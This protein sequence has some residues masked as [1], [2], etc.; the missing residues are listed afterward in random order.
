MKEQARP[1]ELLL[2]RGKQKI[3]GKKTKM[4]KIVEQHAGGA[5]E[6]LAVNRA[7]SLSCNYAGLPAISM[8]FGHRPSLSDKIL[9][10]NA[11]ESADNSY[12]LPSFAL[13]LSLS[14]LSS[15][16][17]RLLFCP[18]CHWQQQTRPTHGSPIQEVSSMMHI[19][20]MGTEEK[21]KGGS[22]IAA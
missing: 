15:L 12:C 19:S 14:L 8:S 1:R 13:V 3:A 20:T 11:T 5:D 9:S 2:H 4:Y 17:S 6:L 22:C 18:P 7:A 16:F 21:E 10:T